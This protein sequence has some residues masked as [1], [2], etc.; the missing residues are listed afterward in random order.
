MAFTTEAGV[1]MGIKIFS[2]MQTHISLNS[3][4]PAKDWTIWLLILEK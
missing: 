1:F 4:S 3:L 2:S